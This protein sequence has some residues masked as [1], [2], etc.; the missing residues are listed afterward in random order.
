MSPATRARADECLDG[1]GDA[2][3]EHDLA[4]ARLGAGES[5]VGSMKICEDGL[6]EGFRYHNA[7]TFHHNATVQAE[8]L[9]TVPVGSEGC[10]YIAHGRRKTRS[11]ELDELLVI[12]VDGCCVSKDFEAEV[13]WRRL[14]L[15]RL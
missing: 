6:A 2:G 11:D 8:V 3:P 5:L 1:G 10:W 7:V 13:D 4:R 12:L 9:T 15:L 14:S